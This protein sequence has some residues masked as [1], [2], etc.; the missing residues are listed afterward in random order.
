MLMDL[1]QQ[2]SDGNGVE[3]PERMGD[4]RGFN[5]HAQFTFVATDKADRFPANG[6]R[7]GAN[8]RPTKKKAT[9]IRLAGFA[10]IEGR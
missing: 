1:Q 8:L 2:V 10:Q 3:K 6:G 9:E 4:A 5:S 7:A